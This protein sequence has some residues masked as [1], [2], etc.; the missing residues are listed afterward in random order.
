MSETLLRS[1]GPADCSQLG[2]ASRLQATPATQVKFPGWPRPE[3]G[4]AEPGP[5]EAELLT[6]VAERAGGVVGVAGVRGTNDEEG[7]DL[8]SVELHGPVVAPAARGGGIG[9]RLMERALEIAG[10]HL[11]RRRIIYN[12]VSP[13]NEAG[14]ELLKRFGFRGSG[15]TEVYF[16]QTS[17]PDSFELPA[18]YEVELSNSLAAVREAY[19]LYLTVWAG[20]KSAGSFFREIENP[21]SSFVVLRR[22]DQPAGFFEQIASP[23][24]HNRIEY[25]MVRENLRG[26][27]LGTQFL[28][29]A[30]RML[31][32]KAR[33]LS[34][35]LSAHE[36]N[37]PARRVYERLGFREVLG[38]ET[39]SR[40]IA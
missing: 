24:G 25:V 9:A 2:F 37:H 13:E 20:R 7:T 39:F 1:L 19:P 16:R 22:K 4:W 10:E 26:R 3:G 8:S 5:G 38:L 29:V 30:L 14:K 6:V 32:E 23:S 18:E 36:T 17:P 27:G 31:W 12:G 21:P 35:S 40:S 15:S 11:D 33:P 28:S 34:L